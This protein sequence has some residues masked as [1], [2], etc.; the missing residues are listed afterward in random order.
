MNSLKRISIFL[1]VILVLS[2]SLL[3]V[4]SCGGDGA[5]DSSTP[6]STPSSDN[7][8]ESKPGTEQPPVDNENL[9]TVTVVDQ[10]GNG[11]EGAVIQICQGENCFGKPIVTGANGTGSR[12]YTLNGDTLKAKILEI[13]GMDDYLVPAELGY[14]YFSTDSRTITITVQEI[15]VSVKDQSGKAVEGA[16]LQLA[17]GEH[18]FPDALITD[19]NGNAS[20]YVAI[21][22]EN[23]TVTV[24]DILSGSYEYSKAPVNVTGYNCNITVSQQLNYKVNIVDATG[25]GMSGIE[26]KLF[27]A[28][29]GYLQ[30]KKTTDSNGA[31]EFEKMQIG[32]YYIT[33]S[34]ISPAY[35]ITTVA[36]DGKY[37]FASGETTLNIEGIELE[38]LT[39]EV[40]VSNGLAGQTIAIYDENHNFVDQAETD[41][42]GVVSFVLENGNYTAI[43]ISYDEIPVVSTPVMF[44]K[45]GAVSGTVKIEENAEEGTESNPIYVLGGRTISVAAGKTVYVAIPN[46]YKKSVGIDC[47]GNLTVGYNG[48]TSEITLDNGFVALSPVENQGEIA[49]ITLT[50]AED[51]FASIYVSAPGTV[52][53]P[54]NLDE[55]FDE[56]NGAK[57]SCTVGNYESIY[58][59]F[60]AKE[61]GVLTVSTATQY[62]YI[63]INDC[64]TNMFP[65]MAGETITI[66]VSSLNSDTFESPVIDAEIELATG[67]VEVDYT[68]T[69]YRDGDLLAGCTVM[70]YMYDEDGNVVIVATAT[71]DE[72]GVV[73][74]EN[75]SYSAQYYVE[76]DLSEMDGYE[77][78]NE[79]AEMGAYTEYEMYISHIKDGSRDYPFEF[80]IFGAEEIALDANQIIYYTR[81][82]FQSVDGTVY[83]I[84]ANNENVVLKAYYQDSYE[85]GYVAVSS[86]EDGNSVLVFPEGGVYLIEITCAED[87]EFEM[88]FTSEEP[89]AGSDY[90]NSY[91]LDEACV[92]IE[93]IE[94]TKYFVFTGDVASVKIVLNGAATLYNVNEGELESIEG[95]TIEAETNGDWLYFAVSCTDPAECEII[96]TVE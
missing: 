23:I 80:D 41:E 91:E 87:V 33:L 12:E 76:A 69:V 66:C 81:V 55:M 31:A 14:V 28:S 89:E 39:Y 20:G 11:I 52:E 34:N 75:I 24:L 13:E 16:K 40:T 54:F 64:E 27:D 79:S 65:M 1:A 7:T 3:V 68:V 48:T 59:Q 73:V 74:F 50:S 61:D 45:Y 62:A 38:E 36:A 26:V 4:C 10:A 49:I 32:E 56:I 71:T 60:V 86:V 90:F 22:G 19:A 15:S 72:N 42:N 77:I 18:V 25:K 58:Y 85:E 47:Y 9:V 5:T 21:S 17:Q 78:T 30:S 37:Y 2:I 6:S 53:N 63:L 57:I 88:E 96:I 82:V 83:K 84:V 94:G 92:H 29:N 67:N 43:L 46:A 51:V 70:L 8:T 44:K 35:V 93:I 95:N